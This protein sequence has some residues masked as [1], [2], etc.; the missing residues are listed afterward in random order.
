MTRLGACWALAIL[1]GALRMSAATPVRPHVDA[2]RVFED[3]R[4]QVELGPRPPGSAASERARRAIA[5]SLRAA[6][7]KVTID[8]FVAPT[9]E[10]EMRFANV[11]GERRGSSRDVIII[12]CHYDTKLEQNFRFVGANDGASGVA[13]VLEIARAVAAN[14]HLRA[15]YRF[16]FFDGEEA[17]C[18][19]WNECLDGRDHLYGSRHEVERL[20]RRGELARVRAMILLDMVGGREL[21]LRRD[22]GSTS[23][24]TDV[25]WGTAARRDCTGFSD[26]LQNITG[27]DHTPFLAEGIP[28][29]DLIDLRYRYWHTA[30]DTLDKLSS[31]NLANVCEIVLAALPEIETGAGVTEGK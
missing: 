7:L 28:A 1:S 25:I 8:A 2:A 26:E 17:I 24:L 29:I 13:A 15:S 16:V 22:V 3:A 31:A 21:F 19:R 20:R 6:G 5:D 10:G 4:R 12:A 23:W 14:R 9:P 27:D 30:E 18:Q 11:I